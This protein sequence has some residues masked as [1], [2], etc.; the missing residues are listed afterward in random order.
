MPDRTAALLPKGGGRLGQPSLPGK[1]N[2]QEARIAL[3]EKKGQLWLE[4]ADNGCSFKPD[5]AAA[6]RHNGH[7]GLVSMRER[8]EMLG[9][10]L[11]IEAKP[12]NGTVV[13]VMVPMN[14]ASKANGRVPGGK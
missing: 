3:L 8:A 4:V 12:G 11:E 10:T 5:Q 7:L 2:S 9:G 6:A 1:A 14:G 13:R